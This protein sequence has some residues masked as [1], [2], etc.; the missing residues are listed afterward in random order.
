MKK[1]LFIA[2]LAAGSFT[3]NS[4]TDSIFNADIEQPL[5]TQKK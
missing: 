1:K 5:L 4:C 3:V 2:L